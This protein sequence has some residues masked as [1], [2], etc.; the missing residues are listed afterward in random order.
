M[1]ITNTEN[2]MAGFQRAM[3]S[4]TGRSLTGSQFQVVW[5]LTEITHREILHSGK[6]KDVLTDFSQTFARHQPF[7]AMKAEI[8]IRDVYASRYDL[9]MK[10]NLKVLQD[11]EATLTDLEK[12]KGHAYAINIGIRIEDGDIPLYRALDKAAVDYAQDLGISEAGAKRVIAE[13]FKAKEGKDFYQWAKETEKQHYTPESR[14]YSRRERKE[15]GQ[16]QRRT[17]TQSQ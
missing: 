11:R 15:D 2:D 12:S 16:A 14:S 8:I 10:A 6:F 13:S 4:K 9:T 3:E 17:R 5:N 1:N 7:D